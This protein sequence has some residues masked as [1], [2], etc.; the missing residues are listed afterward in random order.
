MTAELSDMAA[1][2]N[3]VSLGYFLS[4]ARLEAELAAR[5]SLPR[6]IT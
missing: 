2:V 4:M 5:S 6:E 1:E 3:L